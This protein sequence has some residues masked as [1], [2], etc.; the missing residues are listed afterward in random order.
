MSESSAAP[1]SGVPPRDADEQP[2][3]L[4]DDGVDTPAAS[5][6]PRSRR[7]RRRRDW[8]EGGSSVRRWGW[9][10]FGWAILSL[11]AGVLAASAVQ[12]LVGG[13]VGA[14]LGS[15]VLWAAFAVPV[16][17]ALVRSRP[18]GLLRL[19]PVDLL[20]AVV[21][22]VVLRLVQGWLEQAAGGSGAWPVYPGIGGQLPPGWFYDAV[23]ATVVV[24]P[25][26][27]E[28]FF[29]GV[30]LVAVYSAVRRMAGRPLAAAVATL[31]STALFV[32]AHALLA[33]L[34]WDAVVSLSLLAVVNS[35]LVLATGRIW[36][37]VLVHVVYNAS[38]VALATAGTL[39]LA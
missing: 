39:L 32:M 1:S 5:P 3:E 27:E 31:V 22:G 9:E 7:P 19:R 12:T 11:G 14:V 37:A 21:L 17:L 16:V 8:W 15:V 10:L 33:P 30:V 6:R 23:V 26:L 29:R 34:S 38:W 20:Y 35:V 28:A 25:V 24:A 4:P 13:A 18:R 2:E 36:A